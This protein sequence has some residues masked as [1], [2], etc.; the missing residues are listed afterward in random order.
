M[1]SFAAPLAL[2]G[3]LAFVPLLGV[4][5]FRRRSVRRPVSSLLLW[6]GLVDQRTGGRQREK[7]R[8]PPPL[9]WEIAAL[10]L[11]ALA[12]AA[13]ILTRERDELR[14]V[15]VLD[16]SYSMLA[17]ETMDRAR[18]RALELTRRSG[19]ASF[20]LA[21][22][23]PT[24]LPESGEPGFIQ[25]LTVWRGSDARSDLIGAIMLARETFGPTARLVVFTDHHPEDVDLEIEEMPGLR[26]ISLGLPE[27][28]LGFV[29]AQRRGDDFLLEIRNFSDAPQTAELSVAEGERE[30]SLQ[31]ITIEA[32]DT[33]R[34]RS[35]VSRR[36][37]D[38]VC[39][40]MEEGIEA[41][42]LVHLPA[43]D[44]RPI[45]VGLEL[46]DPHLADHVARAITATGT[47]LLVADMPELLFR[48][49]TDEARAGAFP[50]SSPW[51]VSFAAPSAQAGVFLG[52]YIIDQTHALG[53][54][55]DLSGVI[56]AADTG[57]SAVGSSEFGTPVVMLDRSVLIEEIRS[58]A[59]RELIL[60]LD[61]SRTNIFSTP[62]WPTMIWNIVSWRRGAVPGPARNHLALGESIDVQPGARGEVTHRTPSG[63]TRILRSADR[64]RLPANEAGLHTVLV[65]EREHTVA[66]NTLNPGESDLRR[67]RSHVA[68][69]PEVD[70]GTAL[71]EMDLSWLA[72]LGLLAVLAYHARMTSPKGRD[73]R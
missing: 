43:G 32:D 17:G 31:R 1:P 16:N 12:A 39:T 11:L 55:L 66:V 42:N 62:S 58:D 7:L 61:A 72:A 25:A 5:V 34:L 35:R 4:Y 44:R 27:D 18:D 8:V 40:L 54:G 41:D 3:L 33:L 21:G 56:W 64:L 69:G 47:A 45:R 67:R 6:E 28:N 24:L 65:E 9:P 19:E 38:L 57:A 15:L 26:W 37:A 22:D 20:V 13:P 46:T 10:I 51:V 53:D 70:S 14:V 52:P 59:G 36:G 48:D 68:S 23:R 50:G 49:I 60:R 2:L 73:L 63:A 29:N 30:P 71:A